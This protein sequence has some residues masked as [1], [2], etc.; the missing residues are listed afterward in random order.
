MVAAVLASALALAVP[1]PDRFDGG[2]ALQDVRMQ[3]ALGARPAGSPA[4]RELAGRI[5]RRVPR[6]HFQALP[7]GLR[8]VVGRI[9]GRDPS[10]TVILGAH[11]DTKDLP[12]FVGANDG[13]SGVAVLLELARVIRPRSVR[14]NVVLLFFDGEEKPREEGDFLTEGVRGSRAAVRLFKRR[15]PVVVV[16]MVGDRSLSIPREAESNAA[17]WRRLRAAAV[18]AGAGAAFPPQTRGA[19]YDDHTPFAR[20]GFPA[21]DVIDFTFP[22]WHM[23]CDDLSAVSATSLDRVGETLVAFLRAS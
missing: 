2:R 16:D 3:V 22:C 5:A 18:R 15:W 11:Y 12:G 1:A 19:V 6:A 20:A 10:R 9:Q 7:V 8:N 4:S 13:G 14:P 17:L 21:V 23:L